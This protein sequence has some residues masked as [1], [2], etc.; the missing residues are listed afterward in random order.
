M[1]V[2]DGGGGRGDV[3]RIEDTIWA[4]SKER[5]GVVRDAKRLFFRVI[6]DTLDVVVKY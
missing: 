3:K 2:C 1:R 5:R 4:S 6:K